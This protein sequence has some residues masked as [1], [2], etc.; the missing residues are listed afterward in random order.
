MQYMFASAWDA[1]VDL[2]T[3]NQRMGYSC[4]GHADRQYHR[5]EVLGGSGSVELASCMSVSL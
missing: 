5:L 2:R 4:C 3:G 1:A